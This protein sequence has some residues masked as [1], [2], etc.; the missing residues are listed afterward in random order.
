MIEPGRPC[1]EVIGQKSGK[2]SGNQGVDTLGLYSGQTPFGFASFD[3]SQDR[4]GRCWSAQTCDT[5][6]RRGEPMCSPK[7][8]C[9]P[10]R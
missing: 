1:G 4:Q 3:Y 2:E 9:S 8:V 7:S 5:G 6:A 10:S